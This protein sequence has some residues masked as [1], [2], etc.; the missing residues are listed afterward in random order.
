MAMMKKIILPII[1]LVQ[2]FGCVD[3][4]TEGVT[5]PNYKVPIRF[6]NAYGSDVTIVIDNSTTYNI[7]AMGSIDYNLVNA[8][9]RTIDLYVNGDT[10]REVKALTVN[11]KGTMFI[12]SPNS[13][14]R[15]FT[16]NKERNTYTLSLNDSLPQVRFIN[17][18]DTTQLSVA[19]TSSNIF[20]NKSFVT[21][22][23]VDY[24]LMSSTYQENL[25]LKSGNTFV[26]TVLVNFQAR[27]N[28]TL[29]SVK[30]GTATK[31]LQLTDD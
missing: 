7:S 22:S 18:T 23:V 31:L 3:I 16:F 30:N 14:G 20:S 13:E 11:E 24:E 9:S 27:K 6:V 8:G 25:Y 26:D 5:P 15:Y 19:D 17:A 29:V 1:L 2:F 21:S 28:Y 4:P 10:I 12:H